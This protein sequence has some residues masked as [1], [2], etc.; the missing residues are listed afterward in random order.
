MVNTLIET[1]RKISVIPDEVLRD[2]EMKIKYYKKDVGSNNLF[3]R[4]FK[5]TGYALVDTSDGVA[6]CS[7][8]H[9]EVDGNR[10]PN[11]NIHLR[12][13]HIEEIS[14]PNTDLELD[15]FENRHAHAGRW[16]IPSEEER[17]EDEEPDEDDDS[18]IDDGEL[19]ETNGDDQDID[20]ISSRDSSP[21]RQPGRRYVPTFITE[22]EDPWEDHSDEDLGSQSYAE[23]WNGFEDGR[24]SQ[25]EGLDG[26]Y[27]NRE[28]NG[29]GLY[30]VLRSVE[31]R[32]ANHIGFLNNEDED[33]DEEDL[34][35][36][37]SPRRRK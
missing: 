26:G 10:C 6:R 3:K 16:F 27:G 13:T 35:E 24:S 31:S 34:G 17:S 1:S 28:G 20:Y 37:F 19:G 9:W 33:S 18:F 14:S 7:N 4:V 36:S 30:E 25:H 15:D 29:E 32:V 2:R 11:C 22:E 21:V 8:C 23:S 5:N 12:N